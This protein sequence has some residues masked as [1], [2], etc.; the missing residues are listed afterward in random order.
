MSFQKVVVIS[1]VDST[2]Q[3]SLKS[4][5]WFLSYSIFKFFGSILTIK[6]LNF[7]KTNQILKIEQ[8]AISKG[9]DDF[10]HRFY[11]PNFIKIGPSEAFLSFL[12]QF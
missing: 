10:F 5:N 3:I 6:K 9:G 1:F 11:M 2:C 12:G 8:N 7:E 4:V